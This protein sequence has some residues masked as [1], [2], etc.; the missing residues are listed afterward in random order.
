MRGP[1]APALSPLQANIQHHPLTTIPNLMLCS[2]CDIPLPEGRKEMLCA[3]CSALAAKRKQAGIRAPNVQLKASVIEPLSSAQRQTIS[4]R[5]QQRQ[6]AV[7]SF[8]TYTKRVTKCCST[9]GSPLLFG[10]HAKSKKWWPLNP[11]RTRH[12]CD[13]QLLSGSL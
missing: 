13:Q 2:D 9:C 11:D 8:S 6:S 10:R 7:V 1:S 12:D 5:L 4:E 3:E